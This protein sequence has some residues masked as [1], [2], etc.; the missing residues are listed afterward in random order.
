MTSN[1]GSG[2]QFGETVFISESNGARKVKSNTY[3]A[4]NKNSDPMQKFFVIQCLNS[5]FSK[6]LEFSKTSRAKKLIF[7]LIVNIQGRPTVTDMTLLG[8]WYIV[9]PSKICNPH[10]SVCRL[11]CE[12][13]V[14]MSTAEL[15]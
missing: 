1:K 6:L 14:Q 9:G 13:Q 7:G 8:R 2:A 12:V 11:F 4:M 3:V 5:V 15:R 10:I